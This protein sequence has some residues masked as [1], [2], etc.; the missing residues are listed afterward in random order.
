[1]KRGLIIAAI[2]LGSSVVGA[3]GG[4]ALYSG[5]SGYFASYPTELQGEGAKVIDLFNQP[6]MT[7]TAYSSTSTPQTLSR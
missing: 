4:A 5:T 2:A 7:P 6:H 3:I 1:M